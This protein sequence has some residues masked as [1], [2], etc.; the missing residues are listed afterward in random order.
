MDSGIT[1]KKVMAFSLEN[2][3]KEKV[4]KDIKIQ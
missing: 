3:A 2:K 1:A 4:I